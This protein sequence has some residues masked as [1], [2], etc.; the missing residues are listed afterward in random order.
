VREVSPADVDDAVLERFFAE[1][2]VA[3][4]VRN[5]K[6]QR[7]KVAV[8]WNKLVALTPEQNLTPVKVPSNRQSHRIPWSQFPASFTK[9]ADDYLLWCSV[10]DPLDDEARARALAPKTLRLRRHHIHL[11]ASAAHKAG[12]DIAQLTSLSRLIEPDTFQSILRHE[13]NKKGRPSPYLGYVANTLILMASEWAKVSA[14]QLAALKKLRKKLGSSPSGLTEKNR[15]L[16]RKF[17]DPRLLEALISIPDRLWQAAIRK[18]SSSKW[19]FVDLQTALALDILLHAPLRIENLGALKFDEHLHWP[20][21][22]GKP[23]LI[24]IRGDETKNEEPLEFELPTAL[25]DRL[26]TYRHEIA[27][28]IIGRRPDVLF[29]SNKGVPRGLATLRAVIQKTIRERLGVHITPHQFRHLAAKIHLDSQPGAYELVRQLLG[30][31]RLTTTTS[32]YAGPDTRRAGRAHA[33]LIR[34]L[35]TPTIERLRRRSAIQQ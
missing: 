11:A 32:F 24:V 31:K 28:G 13:W 4:L 12:I 22:R 34:K 15:S 30:H 21:G 18:L 5:L 19:A 14:D 8:V 6:F 1:L 25:S 29:I 10:P 3:S 2:E 7:R 9:D 17:D 35:R 26:Y 20:R 16:L 23:A 33:D 27:A